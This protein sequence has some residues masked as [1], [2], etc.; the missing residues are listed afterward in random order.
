[1][2]FPTGAGAV[3]IVSGLG[4]FDLLEGDGSVRPGPAEGYAACV[5]GAAGP[6]ELGRVGAG[7]GCTSSQVG[8]T[9]PGPTRR[10]RL[11]D[12]RATRPWS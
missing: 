9:G 7:T 2:G 5:A 1:M 10:P 6:V 3:P 4:L 12:R 8:G 11:G